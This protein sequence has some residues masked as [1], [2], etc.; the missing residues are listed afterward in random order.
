MDPITR[1]CLQHY[2]C[3]PMNRYHPF[4]VCK[5][6]HAQQLRPCV[7][8]RLTIRHNATPNAG[9]RSITELMHVDKD[10][11]YSHL[12][13]NMT[14]LLQTGWNFSFTF[15][16]TTTL[17]KHQTY[18]H[19]LYLGL[20]TCLSPLLSEQADNVVCTMIRL[21]PGRSE[22]QILAGGKD[23]LFSET[24]RPALRFT[25]P[26]DQWVAG[27]GVHCTWV[28]WLGCR[29]HHPPPPTPKVTNAPSYITLPPL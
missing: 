24:S 5:N 1:S 29:P 9:R 6:G 23:F 12:R 7:F 11:S 10:A 26:P 4:T 14:T 17:L 22:V 2:V 18:Y 20:P 28:Q 21:L 25:R 15:T 8:V 19:H 16:A 3:L 13:S 27:G